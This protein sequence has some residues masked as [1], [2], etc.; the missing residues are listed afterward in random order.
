MVYATSWDGYVFAL[1]AATGELLWRY[2]AG[3]NLYSSPAV[4]EGVV[5]F[6]SDDG[7]VYALDALIGELLGRYKAGG[8]VFSSPAVVNGIVYV[9]SEDDHAG[10]VN[11]RKWDRSGPEKIIVMK[12]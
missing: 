7:H 10:V 6:G 8:Y 5:F 12:S 4:V 1:G 2:R 11:Q 9:G 3:L